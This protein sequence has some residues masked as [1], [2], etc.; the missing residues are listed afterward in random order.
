MPGRRSTAAV[1]PDH[2]A[3]AVRAALLCSF[4]HQVAGCC[5]FAICWPVVTPGPGPTTGPGQ[6]Q[7]VRPSAVR[8]P[9][10]SRVRRHRVVGRFSGR[11]RVSQPAPA[12]FFFFRQPAPGSFALIG[13]S[14]RPGGQAGQRQPAG[15]RPGQARRPG[16]GQA[17][18]CS[19]QAAARRQRRCR[20]CQ[21]SVVGQVRSGSSSSG[22]AGL[23]GRPSSSFCLRS[24]APAL[25]H[26]HRPGQAPGQAQAALAPARPGAQASHPDQSSGRPSTRLAHAAQPAVQ[27]VDAPRQ[28][29]PALSTGAGQ[30][31]FV[32]L[33]CQVIWLL[34]VRPANFDQL[35]LALPPSPGC[36]L[37]ST[38]SSCLAQLSRSS[39]FFDRC[40]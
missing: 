38:R 36:S 37:R 24:S 23:S 33:G 7:A 1:S 13:G 20:C 40:P 39:Y 35:D 34:T 8:P 28:A 26:R 4:D 14:G 9:V 27:A 18:R 6:G 3:A 2:F 29:A 5:F 22:F 15:F 30:S 12:S 10:G 11:N 21:L 19:G 25:S 17:R 16:S 32:K 31:G